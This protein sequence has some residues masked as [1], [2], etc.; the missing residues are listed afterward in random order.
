MKI[1]NLTFIVTDDC[2]FNCAYCFQKKEKQTI[3][4]LCIEAAVDFFY[5]FLRDDHTNHI[6]FYG[7]EPLL[8]FSRIKLAVLLLRARNTAGQ[9]T[10]KFSLTTNGYLLTGEMLE[11][12]NRHHFGLMLSFDGLA[13]AARQPGSL[14]KTVQAMKRLPAYPDIDVEINSVFSPRTIGRLADSLGFIIRRQGPDLT[15]NLS[16]IEE[17]PP[18][19]IEILA[20]ELKRLTAFL[21][22]HYRQTGHIPVK[23]FRTPGRSHSPGIFR[24]R[25]GEDHLAVSPDGL[26][27]GCYLFHDYFKTRQNTP[28]YREYCFGSLAD[29]MILHKTRYP[30]IMAHYA[31]LHQDLFGVEGQACFLCPDIRSCLVCPVYAAYATGSLGQISRRH[32]LLTTIQS[33]ARHHFHQQLKE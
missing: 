15:F 28:Q 31:D 21:V 19:D 6:N 17:W 29:F 23:N 7:G 13:Q 14:E 4:P 24:C 25:A 2:N 22:R 27:W 5:P 11:F 3:Q 20:G 10:L 18:Q 16:S 9:K 26:V 12:F 32:C 33:Q 30:E 1:S 8:A